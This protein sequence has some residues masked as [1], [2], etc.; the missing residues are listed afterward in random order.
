MLNPSEMSLAEWQARQIE[1]AAKILSHFVENTRP[2]LRDWRP[3]TEEASKTRSVMEQLNECIY[4]N[5]RVLCYLRGEVPVAQTTYESLP[6]ANEALHAGA[7]E[8]ADEVRK[9]QSSG[10]GREVETHRGTMPVA[11]AIQFPLRNMVYHMG[12]INMIQLLYGDATF[13]ID[14][15]FTTL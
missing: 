6:E 11:L 9:I 13:H 8:L 2:D 1:K 14:Q 3:A 15:E 10:L 12:Q 5:H 4:A 7:K